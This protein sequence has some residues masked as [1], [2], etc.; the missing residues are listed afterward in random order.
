MYVQYGDVQYQLNKDKL[1]RKANKNN[2]KPEK[3][4]KQDNVHENTF[5][6]SKKK[7]SPCWIHAGWRERVDMAFTVIAWVVSFSET[8]QREL[9]TNITFY[10]LVSR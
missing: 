6:Q 7:S 5:L 3:Q 8:I 10:V 1:S 4:T 9:R 2:D